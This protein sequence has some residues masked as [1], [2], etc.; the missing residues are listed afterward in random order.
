MKNNNPQLFTQIYQFFSLPANRLFTRLERTISQST[1]AI[2]TLIIFVIVSFFGYSTQIDH[3]VLYKFSFGNVAIVAVSALFVITINQ[4]FLIRDKVFLY[5]GCYL[6]SNISYFHYTTLGVE[7]KEMLPNS[8]HNFVGLMLIGGYFLYMKFAIYFLNLEKEHPNFARRLHF[9]AFLNIVLLLIDTVWIIYMQHDKPRL[10]FGRMIIIFGCIPI[11]IVGIS[12]CFMKL[13]GHLAYIFL[14]GSTFYFLGSV[15]G[16]LFASKLIIN[17]FTNPLM[18]NW[19]FFTEAGT[20]LEVVLFSTGLAYRMRLIDIEKKQIE[21][22]LLR[23]RVKELETEQALLLQRERISH[24][25]HD[26]VGTTLNSIAVYSELALQQVGVDNPQTLPILNRI[27]DASRQLIEVINDIVWVVN[28]QNDRFEN[29]VVKM[30]LFAADLLMPKNVKID[31]DAHERLNRLN[32]SI[33]QRKHFYLIFKE[34]VNNVFKY[35][36]CTRLNIFIELKNGDICLIIADNGRGFAV[37]EQNQGNGLKTMQKRAAI[38]RGPLSVTSEL[39]EGT[40]VLLNFPVNESYQTTQ[41][42]SF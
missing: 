13:R 28:P 6:L 33:E 35:A 38:L 25:L 17:P 2:L 20:I 27:G 10:T 23:Q 31:F 42:G 34:A 21:Q 11:G 19:T 16:F 12:E 36:D 8:A 41:T 18:K 29:I 1:I 22:E 5:Y 9:Y 7:N 30:R 3:N 15:T 14:G 4:F 40:T 32:L 24:D 37:S 39:G 26:D